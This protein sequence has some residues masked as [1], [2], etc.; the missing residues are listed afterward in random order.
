MSDKTGTFP[1]IQVRVGSKE[2]FPQQRDEPEKAIAQT[3]WFLGYGHLGL[4]QLGREMA[5]REFTTGLNQN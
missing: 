4:V 2:C 1:S 3:P 5:G